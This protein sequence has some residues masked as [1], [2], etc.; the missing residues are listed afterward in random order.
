MS[1]FSNFRQWLWVACLLAAATLAGL[2]LGGELSLTSQAMLYVL[3]VALC[4]ARVDW[5]P[6]AVGAVAAVTALNFFFVPPRFTFEVESR[7]HLVALA[8]MLVV[9]LTISHLTASLRRES[10]QVRLSEGRAR[11]LQVLAV[12]LAGADGAEA[13]HALGQGALNEAF[14]G[15]SQLWFKESFLPQGAVTTAPLARAGLDADGL[16]ACL[17]ERAV[18]GPG[19][20]RWPGLNAWYLPVGAMGHASGAAC[21]RPANASDHAGREHAQAIATLVGEAA[22]RLHLAQSV[23]QARAEADRQQLQATFLAAVSHD[24]RTP[25]AAIVAATSSLRTQANRLAEDDRGRMLDIV[26]GEAR[27]LSRLTEN[28]LQLVRLHSSPQA[29]VRA[30]E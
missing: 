25:L 17:R 14:A 4:A 27:Y 2:W 6:S 21:V 7:E 10:A 16:K 28:T 13:I 29:P 12:G 26:E 1:K 30:W 9:A 24:L 5:I 22:D 19:T 3:V 20:G 8:A 11:Q 15:P 18:L 23:A